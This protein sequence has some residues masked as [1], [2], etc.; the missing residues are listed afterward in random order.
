MKTPFNLAWGKVFGEKR[1]KC[2]KPIS[3]KGVFKKSFRKLETWLIICWLRW[4]H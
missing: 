1:L 2:V 3:S 4:K